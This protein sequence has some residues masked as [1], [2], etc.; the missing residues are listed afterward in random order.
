MYIVALLNFDR[1]ILDKSVFQKAGLEIQET[2]QYSVFG[3][4]MCVHPV[5]HNMHWISPNPNKVD[6]FGG[7]GKGPSAT[8]KI[9]EMT[10]EK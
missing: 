10:Q 5:E 1:E 6:V 8:S 3:F 7:K 2:A 4:C 9:P